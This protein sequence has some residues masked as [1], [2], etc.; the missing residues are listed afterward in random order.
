MV[1]IEPG[2]R[3]RG[4]TEGLT[5]NHWRVLV[6][7]F[8]GWIFDGYETYA[9]ISVIGPALL[10]LLPASEHS[11]LTAYAGLAI[12]ITLLGWAVGGVIGGIITDYL[13]RKRMMLISILGY[14]IFTGL[15]AFSTSFVMLVSLRFLTGLFLG[16]EWGTGTALLAE[17]WPT[18]ARPKGAGFM[19]SGFGFGALLAALVWYFI[20]P[21]GAESWRW[22]FLF[23]VI[24]ALFV[25]Y[26]RRSID[27]S[28]KWINALK[29]HRWSATEVDAVS[30]PKDEKRPFTLSQLLSEPHARKR[31]LLALVMSLATTLGWWSIATWIPGFVGGVA[32][33][34][35]LNA[36]HYSS[37][38]GILYNIGAIIGY[39]TAGFVADWLGR[40]WYLAVLMVGGFVM[41]PVFYL[42]THSLTW[43]LIWTVVNAYF[44][45]GSFA[46]MA[47]YLPELFATHLRATASSFVFNASRFLAFLGPIYAGSLIVT[48][49]G[50]PR[51][52]MT[53][54]FIYIV[55]LI[56]VP[57]MPE[58]RGKP[59][60]D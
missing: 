55:G 58:T 51:V 13:G 56:V 10:T 33:A 19:Q 47:I 50:A 23:G 4:W 21:L 34:A 15:T 44:T 18:K 57:F 17:V 48:F 49:H 7:A 16:S 30:V 3:R 35:G 5:R 41:T 46:W 59:L 29:E 22:V 39:L 52:A 12:G 8:L 45:L 28:E 40:R 6:A 36:A 14:A 20:Q 32:K 31:V 38:A 43:L 2:S 53:L 1:S 37:L 54:A 27:E 60:P 25:L 42:W 24:P 11:R 26:I 9:L